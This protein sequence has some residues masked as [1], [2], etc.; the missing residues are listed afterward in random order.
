MALRLLEPLTDGGVVARVGE[1][2]GARLKQEG[3][4]KR[5]R[6]LGGGSGQSSGNDASEE[7]VS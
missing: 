3:R 7:S 4:Q 1:V 5:P 2:L 6:L